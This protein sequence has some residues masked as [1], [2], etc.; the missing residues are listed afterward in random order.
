MA[1]SRDDSGGGGSAGAGDRGLRRTPGSEILDD[2]DVRL[3]PGGAVELINISETGA[4]V[5]SSHRAAVGAAVT[6]CIGGASPQRVPARIVRSQVC[7]IH[8][9]SSMSYQLGL[10]FNEPI[11]VAAARGN[12]GQEDGAAADELGPERLEDAAAPVEPVN[13]W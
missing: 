6:L 12:Q 9:D 7:A 10:A 4:L 8:R 2:G 13:E 5:E 3:S 11:R 1:R